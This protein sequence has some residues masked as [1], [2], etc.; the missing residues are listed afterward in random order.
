METRLR[1]NGTG[2]NI[3]R[4]RFLLLT[5][6]ISAAA[7]ACT[8]QQTKADEPGG[9]GDPVTDAGG[10]SPS[11]AAD[12]SADAGDVDGAAD[13]DSGPACIGDQDAEPSCAASACP[14]ECETIK[15]RFKKGVANQILGCMAMYPSCESSTSC[16]AERGTD[17][18]DAGRAIC[19]DATATTF[20]QPLVDSCKAND[21]EEITLESCVAMAKILTAAG[22]DEFTSCITEG[23]A[24]YCTYGSSW[25]LDAMRY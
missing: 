5:G 14:T 7:V 25:C 9:A 3:D 15:T 19:E 13:A 18:P 22:R 8:I 10:N 16:I 2:L 21:G 4:T 24:G 23:M 12:G 11:D 1:G 6:M 20:C 17:D